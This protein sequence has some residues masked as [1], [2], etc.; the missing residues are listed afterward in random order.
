LRAT[1][2]APFRDRNFRQL[3]NFLFLWNFAANL[4]IPFFSVFM[5]ERLGM[6]LSG[7]IALGV[8][9]QLSRI[10]FAR[11]WGPFADK[12][13]SKAVLS[14]SV[15]LYLLVILGWAYTGSPGPHFLTVPLL[16]VLHIFAGVATSGINLT[17]M[18]LRM[19][20]A[21]QAQATAYLTG[22]SLAINLGSGISPLIGGFL[23]DFFSV[24]ELTLTFGWSGPDP[25]GSITFAPLQ[26]TGFDFFLSWLLSWDF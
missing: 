4:A 9:S 15:S 6:P 21:P 19:K 7:V 10:L 13:G 11:V 5:L 20:L 18:T 8:L 23:A 14:L 12:F 25:S 16:V 2:A 17:D 3:I 26:L 1:L 22:A 24:R